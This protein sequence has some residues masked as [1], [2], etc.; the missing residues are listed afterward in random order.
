MTLLT[1]CQ[2]AADRIGLPRPSAVIASTDQQV[3]ELL[4]F[5]N[6]EGIELM[7]AVNWQELETEHTFTTSAAAAQTSSIPSD[8]DRFVNDS[9]FNRTRERKM[10]GPISAQDW[11]QRQAYSTA[12][13][14]EYWW[15]LRGGAIL[16]TPT[17]AAGET[18]AYEYISE[19]W[20]LDT[21]GTTTKAAWAADTDT[22]RL[23]EELIAL[24]VR[25]RFLKAKGLEWTT[26]FQEY[27]D[28][29]GKRSVQQKGAP[30]LS[31]GAKRDIY[32]VNVPETGFG[33]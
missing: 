17:P 18:I 3:R 21:D 32:A 29:V 30:K 7:K 28:Q 22:A 9:M 27:Q 14:I 5:A 15:R 26:A 20:I 12:S 25:W 4:A 10:H 16:I 6:Q 23:P 24:G 8:W 1:I 19:N 2:S 11:Q 33:A 31:A 13:A